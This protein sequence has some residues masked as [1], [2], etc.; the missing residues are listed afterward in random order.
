MTRFPYRLTDP[1]RAAVLGLVVLKV[2]ETIEED[3]RAAF[4]G[5]EVALHISRVA[6]GDDL[7]PDTIAE[8][9]RCLPEAASLLPPAATFDVV[10]YGCTSGTALIGAEEVARLVGGPTGARAVTDPLTAALEALAALGIGRIGIVSPYIPSVSTPI[11]R[12]FEAGGIEVAQALSFGEEV[13]ARVARIDP[14]STAEA[15]RQ[16]ARQTDIGAV[17]LSCTNLRTFGIIDALEEDLGLP[18]LSS[19]QV[20]AWHMARL[21]GLETPGLPGRLGRMG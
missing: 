11:I 5:R 2:D 14:A 19:N 15:A 7:T 12:A 10:G 16:V 3:F 18:V 1:S 6:S 21:A 8:M 4:P 9:E 20:L 17:F 13:E